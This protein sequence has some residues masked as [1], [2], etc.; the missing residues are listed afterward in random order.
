MYTAG[1]R[2]QHHFV[3]SVTMYDPMFPSAICHP[4]GTPLEHRHGKV[5]SLELTSKWKC[6]LMEESVPQHKLMPSTAGRDSCQAPL[7]AL[8]SVNAH[9]RFERFDGRCLGVV[10]VSGPLQQHTVR[11]S[12]IIL[13]VFVRRNRAWLTLWL[14]VWLT[15]FQSRILR[16]FSSVFSFSPSFRS[17]FFKDLSF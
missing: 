5:H 8:S 3:C 2:D 6:P 12:P 4:V 9:R 1:S 11:W 7:V 13:R 17:D 10:G 15:E 14:T 16:L